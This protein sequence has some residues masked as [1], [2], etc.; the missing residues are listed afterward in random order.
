MEKILSQDE[1]NALFSTMASEGAA[2]GDNS[3]GGAGVPRQVSRYDFCRSDRVAKDQIRSLHAIHTGLARCLSASLSA[4]LRSVVEVNLLSVDQVAYAEFLKLVSDPTLIC[5]V[6]MQPM[7]G[8]LAL[9]VNPALTFP[10][11]DILLGGPGN[12]AAENRAL[13]EIEMHIVE[14]VTRL[15]LRDLKEAWRPVVELDPRMEA[16]ETKPQMLQLVAPSEAVVSIGFE[17]KLAENTG[18]LH[19]C[20]PSVML[21]VNRSK[22]DQQRQQRTSET[23]RRDC[24]RIGELVRDARVKL[25]GVLKE[26]NLL[27][28]DL[29]TFSAGD[30]IQLNQ[31]LGDPV[32]VSVGGRAKF[33]AR[34][35]VRRGKKALEITQRYNS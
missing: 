9:E 33:L 6:G 12:P 1:I 34:I 20:I 25:S 35:V 31:R 8:S 14:A 30:V 24:A 5:S 29:L 4:Y 21:K 32:L 16:M 10:M 11:I 26:S 19:L 7:H 15:I 18:M 28:E 13:T 2:F 17:V 27:V 22:F 23:N 3:E